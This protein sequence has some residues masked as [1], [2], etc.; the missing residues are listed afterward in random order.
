[1]ARILPA[2]ESHADLDDGPGALPILINISLINIS[3]RDSGEHRFWSP[4][5]LRHRGQR[6]PFYG[7]IVRGREASLEFQNYNLGI[8]SQSQRGAPGSCAA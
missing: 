8:R 6:R 3:C 1:M 2:L 4:N 5:G 7:R